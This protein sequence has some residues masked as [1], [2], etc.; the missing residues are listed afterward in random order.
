MRERYGWFV[1]M[2]F[3]MG[4]ALAMNVFAF[5]PSAPAA[6]MDRLGNEIESMFHEL[7]ERQTQM[8][9]LLSE[10]RE[11][12]SATRR[13]WSEDP[14]NADRDA[15]VRLRGEL[16]RV[17]LSTRPLA[18][19]LNG[20][21]RRLENEGGESLQWA[22]RIDAH[23]ENRERFERVINTALDRIEKEIEAISDE[24]EDVDEGGEPEQAEELEQTLRA[25]DRA[26]RALP[27]GAGPPR[28]TAAR[29][30]MEIARELFGRL[31]RRAFPP[32]LL[33]FAAAELPGA[34]EDFETLARR[35]PRAADEEFI[36][37]WRHFETMRR[38][39]SEAPEE[40]SLETRNHA[41]D[42]E[43]R[44]LGQRLRREANPEEREAIEKRLMELLEEQF[45]LRQALRAR[46]EERLEI[47]LKELNRTL[48]LRRQNRQRIILRRFDELTG[49]AESL[50]W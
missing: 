29:R 12:A 42:R 47:Q 20:L 32:D 7:D 10:L 13:A 27:P 31:D 14:A 39:K 38:M 33:E 49:Q 11:T 19:K 22:R 30:R 18:D 36:P 21:A 48:E 9:R 41:L 28:E 5:A 44:S 6:D 37:L 16:E 43:T 26:L 45:E 34:L 24:D 46:E 15:C 25:I 35:E 50:P 3:G 23:L 8:E 4:G 2:V 1:V 17:R 40:Y